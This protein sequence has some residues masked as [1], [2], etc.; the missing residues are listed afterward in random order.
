[1]SI[2]LYDVDFFKYH[3][4][5]FNLEIMKLAS[6]FKNKREITVLSP[7]LSPERYAHFYLRKDYYDGTF[8][9]RLTHYD[10]LSYGGLAFT[11]KLYV[12]LDEDIEMA[13]PDTHV[14]DKYQNLFYEGRKTH[15]SIFTSLVNNI[16]LRLSLDGK[17]VWNN[18]EKQIP[19][20][21]KTN[22]MFFHDVDL[23]QVENSYEVIKD[24]LKKYSRK[25][26]SAA[27]L[28]VKFP[29]TC[30]SYEN[31]KLWDT[32]PFSD[33]FFNIKI[34]HMLND[35]EFFDIINNISPAT[36]QKIIYQ[37]ASSSSDKTLFVKDTLPKIFKQVIFCCNQHKQI[38]L[39]ISDDFKIDQE[40]KDLITLFNLYL[41]AAR[42]YTRVPALYRFCKAL[43]S[44]DSLRRTD[45]MSK[46]QARDLFLFIFNNHQELFK[47]F[48]ECNNVILKGGEF[49]F[50]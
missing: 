7:T 15:V 35:E 43:K 27:S 17:T 18:F 10:N 30:N 1:M 44:Q 9:P 29:I 41:S 38:S 40:W 39:N 28:G 3:Q 23:G 20:N 21:T 34:D 46:E 8:P 42:N 48:Y 2:G 50:D 45:I 6:Y 26:E 14:Y 37:V 22:I 33:N 19:K 5:M 16:H 36:G 4:V 49:H 12:P 31:F 24:L 47:M 11:G 32:L 25:S 13:K